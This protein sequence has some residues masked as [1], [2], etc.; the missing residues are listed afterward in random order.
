M[1]LNVRLKRTTTDSANVAQVASNVSTGA[2]IPYN[3]LIGGDGQTYEARGWWHASG[4]R[5][6]PAA[7]VV[8]GSD[9]PPLTVA[10]AGDYSARLPSEAQLRQA[11]TLLAEA[12]LR[13]RLRPDYRAY[14]VRYLAEAQD[15][16]DALW[17]ELSR[18][19][20]RHYD[21]VIDV[22]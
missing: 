7:S 16:G 20:W 3:F 2:D 9:T 15:N 6:V 12:V 14:G 4:V 17:R 10:F 1:V 22:D 18:R 19:W 5:D 8:E 13:G 21:A 11:E